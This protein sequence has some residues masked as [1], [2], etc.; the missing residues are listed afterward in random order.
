MLDGLCG[1]ISWKHQDF[2]KSWA[3]HLRLSEI[4]S[5]YWGLIVSQFMYKNTRWNFAAYYL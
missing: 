3:K 2:K 5:L 4:G 1:L